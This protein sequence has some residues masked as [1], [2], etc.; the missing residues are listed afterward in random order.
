M[1][2]Q[3]GSGS[4]EEDVDGVSRRRLQRQR[5][6]AGLASS[7]V[8][9][10]PW[11][12]RRSRSRAV[13]SDTSMARRCSPAPGTRSAITKKRG[14]AVLVRKLPHRPAQ[15]VL[16]AED[17]VV[18]VQARPVVRLA[19]GE[20]ASRFRARQVDD[21]NAAGPRALDQPR[22]SGRGQ[23]CRRRIRPCTTSAPRRARDRAR[24][25]LRRAPQGCRR[26]SPRRRV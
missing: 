12:I 10:S 18:L 17:R 11:M 2:I 25:P 13:T 1:L 3:T 15:E 4:P 26:G 7:G 8:S 9:S 21:V 19:L 20:L 23:P 16:E 5:D 24:R 6:S 14:S 22:A